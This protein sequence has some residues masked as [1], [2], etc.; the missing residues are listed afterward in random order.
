MQTIVLKAE[1]VL[2]W[3]NKSILLIKS[4]TADDWIHKLLYLDYKAQCVQLSSIANHF[5][6]P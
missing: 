3:I 1:S 6:W 5:I 2:R 4:P